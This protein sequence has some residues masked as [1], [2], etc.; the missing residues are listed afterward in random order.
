MSTSA[1]GSKV[2]PLFMTRLPAEMQRSQKLSAGRAPIEAALPRAM[3]GKNPYF[4]RSFSS[5]T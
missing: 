5:G 2:F 4:S 3:T 1:S